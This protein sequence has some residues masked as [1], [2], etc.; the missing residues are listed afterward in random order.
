MSQFLGSLNNIL[1]IFHHLSNAQY[2]PSPCMKVIIVKILTIHTVMCQII[3]NYIL[4]VFLYIS[5]TDS[6]S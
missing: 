2:I 5:A 1:K 3:A 4:L 6:V